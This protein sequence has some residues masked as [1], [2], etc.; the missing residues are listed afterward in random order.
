[1]RLTAVIFDNDATAAYDRMI[2]SQCMILSARAGVGVK[3]IE[4]KLK[5]LER[6]QY[7]VKTAY[8]LS[9]SSFQNMFL[10]YVISLLQGSSEV[11]PIWSL[12]SSVQFDI[13]DKLY[14]MA[15]FPSPRP[16]VFTKRNGESFV[17]DTTLWETSMTASL[18]E[19]VATM[20]SK[21]QAWE[22]GVHVAGGALNLLKTFFYAVSGKY[23][24]NGQPT[25]QTVSDDPDFAIHLTQGNTRDRTKSINQVE[26]TTGKCT[27]GVRLAPNGSDKT[28]YEYRLAEAMK[29]RPRLLRAP[30]NREST[31]KGFTTMILQK[32]SY[33]LGATCFTE[34]ECNMIQAKFLPTVLSKMG[35]NRSTPRDV[36][37]GPSLYAGMTV[38]E[39]WSIQGS[40]KNK[41]LIG[42]L[43]KAD[44][45]ADN[46][47]VELDCLQLQA[48]MS[49]DVLSRDG[50]RVRPYVDKCW[51]SH[52]WEFND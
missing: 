2:P 11:C 38:S 20:T 40:S 21:A 27:L 19:V 34:K 10:R 39:L 51:A 37:S 43:R 4:M 14:P 12:S 22:R 47:Q 16:E 31:R 26:V 52:L 44:M 9:T 8:G 45:V 48:G 24:K 32:F 42:H 33:P 50:T 36:R 17:D 25:M 6:M 23:K 29:L 15:V 30:M 5:V 28:E 18:P 3:P 1:M 7:Y 41:L 49:W 46:L 13:M 35:I